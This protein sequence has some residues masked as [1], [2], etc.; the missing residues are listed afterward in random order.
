MRL[1]MALSLT[2]G[3]AAGSRLAAAQGAGSPTPRRSDSLST[4]AT[5]MPR[6]TGASAATTVRADA[7]EP[8]RL[9]GLRKILLHDVHNKLVHFP[10]V[11]SGVAAILMLLTR[12][13]PELETIAVW[14]VWATG[15]SAL[16]AYFTGMQQAEEFAGRPKE[17]LVELHEKWGI[18]TALGC[19]AWLLLTLKPRWKGLAQVFGVAVAA[20]ALAAGFLGGLVAHSPR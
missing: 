4:G 17:W 11:L 1:C 6:D 19:A 3:L 12:R 5:A 13:R 15:V 10:I 18:A 16:A 9:P 7:R 20:L 8:Y 14:F 2:A